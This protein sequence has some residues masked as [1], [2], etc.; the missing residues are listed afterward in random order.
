[1]A[2]LTRSMELARKHGRFL[3]I[4]CASHSAFKNDFYKYF[5]IVDVKLRHACDYRVIFPEPEV[6]PLQALTDAQCIS[7]N[8]VGARESKILK[9]SNP[10]VVFTGCGIA[11]WDKNIKV[12]LAKKKNIIKAVQTGRLIEPYIAVHYRNTDL[13]NDFAAFVKTIDEASKEY[14]INNVYIASD[15]FH[16]L[17]RFGLALPKLEVTGFTAP[18]KNFKGNN[19]HYGTKD[20]DK[21]IM[22]C[23]LD[24]YM[25]VKSRVFIGSKNSSLSKWAG[26]MIDKKENIFD[27][28]SPECVHIHLIDGGWN[29]YNKKR[30]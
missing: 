18:E 19:I 5:S 12:T 30:P 2:G 4:D 29:V 17:S 26:Y 7:G 1:M 13:K 27:A 8:N 25:M 14:G 20:K 24:L 23:L 15:D 11:R 21:V 3:L 6:R 16:A 28:E 9:S 22:D 10:F